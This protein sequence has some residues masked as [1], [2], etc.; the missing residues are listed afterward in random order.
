MPQLLAISPLNGPQ[1]TV[2][3]PQDLGGKP[4]RYPSN[5]NT[6]SQFY[7]DVSAQVGQVS[8]SMDSKLH[9]VNPSRC[10]IDIN[11]TTSSE[12]YYLPAGSTMFITLRPEDT[13]VNLMVLTDTGGV[14]LSYLYVYYIDPNTNLAE[15]PVIM[16]ADVIPQARPICVP[17]IP[18]M[19]GS[20][21][22]I[23][24]AA[25]TPA[26][27]DSW[28]PTIPFRGTYVVYVSSLSIATSIT[29]LTGLCTFI[30]QPT[31]TGVSTGPNIYLH[32]AAINGVTS[33]DFCPATP[34]AIPIQVNGGAYLNCDGILLAIRFPA[35]SS[36]TNNFWVSAQWDIDFNNTTPPPFIGGSELGGTSD[37][38]YRALNTVLW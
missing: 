19:N 26:T 29:P 10:G 14:G 9:F 36:P 13:R 23:N 8:Q 21:N 3:G 31:K 33:Y 5:P 20:T 7:I 17:C 32:A 1:N 15:T 27:V 16:N 2:P 6:S 11:M 38:I 22:I 12:H 18:N 25:G 37:G 24:L 30:L 28:T 34:M 35:L 4:A